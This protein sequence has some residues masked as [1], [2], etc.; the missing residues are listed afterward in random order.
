MG[1]K[2]S[3]PDPEL[4]KKM[5]DV[6]IHAMVQG[7]GEHLKLAP[8]GLMGGVVK[9]EEFD[10]FHELIVQEERARTMCPG[11]EDGIDG[12][13]SIGLPVVIKYG[14]NWMKEKVLPPV[15]RGEETV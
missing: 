15:F 12:A 6:G 10:Y 14:P 1:A 3:E 7:P 9:P 13:C 5:G 11:Y 8:N 2:A 4:R